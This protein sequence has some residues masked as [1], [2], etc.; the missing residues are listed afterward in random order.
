MLTQKSICS[1]RLKP[2]TDHQI[3]SV[4]KVNIF[5]YVVTNIV[6]AK[7]LVIGVKGLVTLVLLLEGT[8]EQNEWHFPLPAIMHN[9]EQC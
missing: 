2:L 9:I 3:G 6:E 5:F 7:T 4:K 1:T 8:F